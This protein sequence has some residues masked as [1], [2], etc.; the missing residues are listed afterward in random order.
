MAHIP[1]KNLQYLPYLLS[2]KTMNRL[3]LRW[4]TAAL[5]CTS[6]QCFWLWEAANILGECSIRSKIL[7]FANFFSNKLFLRFSKILFDFWIPKICPQNS[8][9]MLL[10][11]VHKLNVM[12]RTTKLL[13]TVQLE[14]CGWTTPVAFLSSHLWCNYLT[15]LYS[16]IWEKWTTAFKPSLF[17]G[18][19]NCFSAPPSAP[20]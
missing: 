14:C 18:S 9:I 13:P 1:H 20:Q 19:V 12:R 10:R 3:K 8:G 5:R 16:V 6:C 17:Q 11:V 2:T 15:F 7:E 4:E